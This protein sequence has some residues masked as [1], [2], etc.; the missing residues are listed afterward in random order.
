LIAPHRFLIRDGSNKV[1]EHKRKEMKH[2][3]LF[4]D[5]FVHVKESLLKDGHDLSNPEFVWPLNLVWINEALL[6]KK[7]N[8]LNWC[9]DNDKINT[10]FTVEIIG[11]NGSMTL[12]VK[13][14]QSWVKDLKTHCQNLLNLLNENDPG[15]NNNNSHRKGKYTYPGGSTYD[16]DWIDGRVS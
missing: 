11:P 10:W 5:L 7:G 8:Y 3:F 15:A 6:P 12:N 2:F 9:K 14:D 1:T 16:G 13:N 4:N